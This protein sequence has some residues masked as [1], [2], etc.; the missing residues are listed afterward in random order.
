MAAQRRY[1][2]FMGLAVISGPL[3]FS[4]IV[5]ASPAQADATSYLNDVHNAGI[6]DAGGDSALLNTGQRLCLEMGD[7]A[8]PGQLQALAVQRSDAR[9]GARALTTQQ[10]DALVDYAIVDLCPNY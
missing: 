5:W 10:A 1:R 4:G 3:L 7:G 6:R 8:S 2:R 9:E